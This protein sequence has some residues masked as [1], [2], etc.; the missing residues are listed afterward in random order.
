[1]WSKINSSSY[2]DKVKRLLYGSFSF[3]SYK[4]KAHTSTSLLQ[5]KFNLHKKFI[6]F[7]WSKINSLSYIDKAKRLIY[8]SSWFYSYKVNVHTSTFSYYNQKYKKIIYFMWS[9]IN[10]LSY[11]D[12]AKRLIY[13]S[14]WF[15]SYKV[16]V[17]TS[18][19]SY[20]NQK[21][22]FQKSYE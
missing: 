14:S 18:T 19:F 2:I 9:K 7:I 10:S 5:P 3:Y 6:Y 20:Y 8:G 22:K 4:V 17:H 21:Y 16:N 13:G 15:Y 11:I 1:M 12:K